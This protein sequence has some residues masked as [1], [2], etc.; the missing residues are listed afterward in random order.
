MPDLPA[1]LTDRTAF[2]LQLAVARVQALGE[3]ALVEVGVTGREYGAMAV[4]AHLAPCTQIAVG[5]ALGI[6]RTTTLA[7]MTGLEAR[8]LVVRSPDPANRRA[9]LVSLTPDGDRVRTRAA[10]VLVACEDRFLAPLDDAERAHLHDA[11]ARLVGA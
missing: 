8:G 3:E 11:L 1:A 6:D 9:Y 7:V 10:E 5:R 2:L 4:L